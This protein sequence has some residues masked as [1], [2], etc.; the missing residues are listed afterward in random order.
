M[1]SFCNNPPAGGF[2]FPFGLAQNPVLMLVDH[3]NDIETRN[4]AFPQN[5]TALIASVYSKFL[6][7]R[8][9]SIQFSSR[10]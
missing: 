9:P 5:M 6:F 3:S 4:R 7:S 2:F 8:I 10:G 1:T